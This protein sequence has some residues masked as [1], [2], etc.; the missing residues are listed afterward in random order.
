MINISLFSVMNMTKIKRLATIGA[1][2]A[3]CLCLKA[4]TYSFV[5][6]NV[7]YKIID[8]SNVEVAWSGKYIDDY[9]D[10]SS[11]LDGEY[12]Y[13]E[14]GG[15]NVGDYYGDVIVPGHVENPTNHVKYKVIGVGNSA[16]ANCVYLNS[17]TL[18]SSIEYLGENA[19]GGASLIEELSLPESLLKIGD[20]CF[21][22]CIK[23]KKINIPGG[24]TEIPQY[25]FTKAGCFFENGNL[26][27]DGMENIESIGNYAFHKSGLAELPK[28]KNIK[29]I[30]RNA[31]SGCR[32]T[33]I[34]FSEYSD[35]DIKN[36]TA[37]AFTENVKLSEITLPNT[38]R[39]YLN[40]MFYQCYN[41]SSVK[42]ASPEP[43]KIN[44][45]WNCSYNKDCTLYVPAGS[46]EKYKA[47]PVWGMFKNIAPYSAEPGSVE[48]VQ[49]TPRQEAASGVYDF[50]G[51]K[52][53]EGIESADNLKQGTYII[54]T[55]QATRKVIITH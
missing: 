21:Y 42:I 28:M 45:P 35:D 37:N 41:I 47:H 17:V 52:I 23:L 14:D 40:R 10:G 46:V 22:E 11:D 26:E 51:Y 44:R 15:Y 50:S 55:P 24:V 1:L 34:D 3:G 38:S 6:D 36:I 32:L 39:E 20:Y 5:A 30:G 48:S 33:T 8:S 12:A 53:A 4:Q 19:F 18:P 7:Y 25:A 13:P 49:L 9:I 16:F 54:K 31:F 29:H 43:P 2:A 27:I